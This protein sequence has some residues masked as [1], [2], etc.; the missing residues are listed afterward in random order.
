[1]SNRYDLSVNFFLWQMSDHCFTMID[2][3]N[4][5]RLFRIFA[6]V[7]LAKLE[8]LFPSDSPPHLSPRFFL[9]D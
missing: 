1:M 6:P 3:S 8:R 4:A 7:L 2:Y 9:S 5:S